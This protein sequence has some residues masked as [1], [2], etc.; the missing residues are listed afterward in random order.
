MRMKKKMMRARVV[1]KRNNEMK[2]LKSL[3]TKSEYLPSHLGSQCL[4]RMSGGSSIVSGSVQHR[5]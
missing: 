1:R 3:M 2:I 5:V 4:T